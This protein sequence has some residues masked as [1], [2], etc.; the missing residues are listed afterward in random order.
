MTRSEVIGSSPISDGANDGHLQFYPRRFM[1]RLIFLSF[2]DGQGWERFFRQW[3]VL[4]GA[5][6]RQRRHYNLDGP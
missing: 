1:L 4:F 6:F 3:E 5:H 2:F